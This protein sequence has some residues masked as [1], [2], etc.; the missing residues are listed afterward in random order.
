[1]AQL[2]SKDSTWKSH[3]NLSVPPDQRHQLFVVF[4]LPEGVARKVHQ[5]AGWSRWQNVLLLPEVY[6]KVFTSTCAFWLFEEFLNSLNKKF[7][8]H[9]CFLA[10]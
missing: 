5:P 7:C 9:L 6:Q 1:M 2:A 8:F 4:P 3:L 10:L